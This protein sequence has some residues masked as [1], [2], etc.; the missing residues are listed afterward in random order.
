MAIKA[1]DVAK[2]RNMTGS[3]MMD[4][5]KALTET[6]GDLDAAVDLLRKKG[7]KVASK[8]ADRATTEGAALAKVNADGKSGA[9]IVLNCETDFVAKNED[10]VAFATNILDTALAQAPADLAALAATQVNGE[11]IEASITNKSGVTGEKIEL[12]GYTF[13]KAER[14]VAYIHPGNKV[15]TLV[16]FNEDCDEQVGKDVAMQIAAMSPVA[17]DKDN[18]DEAT[19]AREIEVGKELAINEG[20]P[21]AMAEK[22]AMGRLNKFFAESTLLNQSFVKNNK[23]T[24][25]QYLASQSKT[26]T[27]TAFQRFSLQA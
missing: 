27:V 3:G 21:A 23:Q 17:I 13:I 26:L 19:I 16:G 15:A 8:R 20:K 2:L 14:V 12:G 18:V 10:Y 24:I 5:K 7:Q 11:A 22:I 1:S 6:E 9:I 25:K 4:C